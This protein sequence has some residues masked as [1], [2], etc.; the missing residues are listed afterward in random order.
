MSAVHSPV[1][2]K[3]SSRL[4]RSLALHRRRKESGQS[5]SG[6]YACIGLGG[7][8]NF[9]HEGKLLQGL[10]ISRLMGGGSFSFRTEKS[11]PTAKTCCCLS[12]ASGNY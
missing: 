12:T 5:V 9:S 3:R 11:G 1:S 4:N 6:G 8:W 7:L 2:E 10:T